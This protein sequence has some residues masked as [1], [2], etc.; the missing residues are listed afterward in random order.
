MKVR[1]AYFAVL[2]VAIP[3][4]AWNGF[5]QQFNAQATDI[6]MRLRP[7]TAGG[8]TRDL[9]LVAIDDNTAARFGPLPLNRAAL[10]E[11]LTRLAGYG[12]A[13]VAV[14]VLI[15]EPG[16]EEA[17]AALAEAVGHL[18]RVI[19]AAALSSDPEGGGR[20][21]LPLP[22]LRQTVRIAHV[23]AEPDPDG[24]VRS[25]MLDKRAGGVRLWAMGLE[26]VALFTGA[27]RP[28]EAPDW[29]RL[30]KREIPASERSGRLLRINYAG[31]EG[32][33]RRVSFTALMD[34]SARTGEFRDKAV[35]LGATAQGSGDRHFT[36][37]SSGIGMSGIEIHAN[38]AR[39]I[40]DGAFLVPLPIPREA[41]LFVLITGLCIGAA[42]RLRGFGLAGG[43]GALGVGLAGASYLALLA[44]SLWPLGS[45]LAVMVTAATVSLAGEYASVTLA[46][47]GAE[48][49]RKDYAFRVQA[50]AHEIKNPLAAI[51]GSS[52]MISDEELPDKVRHQMAGLIHK[53]SRRLNTLIRTFLEVERLAAGGL[54]LNRQPV[55]LA[56]L[57]ADVL[58]QA[59]LYAAKK[60]INVQAEM[61]PVEVQADPDLLAFAVY[62]LLTNAVKYSPKGTT[63]RLRLTAA[64]GTAEVS[65]ADE[66]YGIA[67]A[68]QQK[69]FERFYRLKRD[70][71]SAEE[72]TGIGLAMV[73]E[74]V[75]QHGGRVEVESRPGSG[76]KFTLL[77]P[78]V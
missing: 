62:N 38:L 40:L 46:L 75:T 16:D 59:R 42:M 48:E 9:V 35:I 68:E 34:G 69:I 29:L 61:A 4:I 71:R 49:K 56:G 18:P 7:V 66:G 67:P 57:C 55:Q 30:G 37:V 54:E 60:R 25:V 70:E 76:S 41:A 15:A 11:G 2:L 47:R 36:P 27:G 44:G 72:G 3:W 73:K 19:A 77:I 45:L 31:P 65:V 12:P 5:V 10:A 51:Q 26:V 24:V 50:I 78:R 64:D 52:E 20:W 53:E 14:D 21:V 63:V 6:L 58:D 39:T 17:D 8:A 22:R 28:V 1:A 74:I 32:T 13:V 43:L 33:F 23:H